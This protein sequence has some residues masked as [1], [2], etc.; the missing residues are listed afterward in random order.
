MVARKRQA[1]NWNWK[2]K[3]ATRWVR[4][5]AIWKWNALWA[6]RYTTFTPRT[7]LSSPPLFQLL[8]AFAGALLGSDFSSSR[9]LSWTELLAEPVACSVTI[10]TCSSQNGKNG[11]FWKSANLPIAHLIC[12]GI[13]WVCCTAIYVSCGT[14]GEK[15]NHTCC[16]AKCQIC[17]SGFTDLRAAWSW[18]FSSVWQHSS[19]QC[20]LLIGYFN[21]NVEILKSDVLFWAVISSNLIRSVIIWCTVNFY[22]D[23]GK[24]AAC[25]AQF[26]EHL[27]KVRVFSLVVTTA[28]SWM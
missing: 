2:L 10:C 14:H 22:Q 24:L 16:F 5:K 8:K 13:L 28:L 19:P 6:A 7:L 25:S 12:R 17:V 20:L 27:S 1:L 15:E 23:A 9:T 21:S 11:W 3:G 4:L 18:G 26:C